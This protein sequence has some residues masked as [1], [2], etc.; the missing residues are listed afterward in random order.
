MRKGDTTPDKPASHT[1]RGRD[2]KHTKDA[3]NE[4][5]KEPNIEEEI[6]E[7][8]NTVTDDMGITY[9]CKYSVSK[10]NDGKATFNTYTKSDILNPRLRGLN[11]YERVSHPR[12]KL[13]PKEMEAKKKG[14][15]KDAFDAFLEIVKC[16]V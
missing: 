1:P 4:E 14:I 15:T 11:L 8:N 3:P 5:Y 10:N 13:E 16:P 2:R 7:S 9:S 6:K 12:Y